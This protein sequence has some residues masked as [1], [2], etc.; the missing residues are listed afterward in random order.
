M[1]SFP[2][3]G[4][5]EYPA[6]AGSQSRFLRINQG[7]S[8][9]RRRANCGT[10][11][12]RCDTCD[13]QQAARDDGDR[14][15][16]RTRDQ[17]TFDVADIATTGDDKNVERRDATPHASGI[18]SCCSAPRKTAD[19]ASAAP[20]I[21]KHVSASQRCRPTGRAVIAAPHMRLRSKMAEPVPPHMLDPS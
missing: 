17:A 20:A 2:A 12:R 7:G 10:A 14:R 1:P 13:A 15:R 6:T 5:P 21:A 8:P 19:T 9:I 4:V 18:T 16:E 11:P 3:R